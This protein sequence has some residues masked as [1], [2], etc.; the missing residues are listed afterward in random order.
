MCYLTSFLIISTFVTVM[1]KKFDLIKEGTMEKNS[2][3]YVSV[4]D[5]SLSQKLTG[6]MSWAVIH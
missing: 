1:L 6:K 5:K 2:Y 3:D 4:D